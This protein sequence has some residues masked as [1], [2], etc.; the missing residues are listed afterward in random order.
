MNKTILSSYKGVRI[1]MT[2]HRWNA[3]VK[4]LLLVIFVQM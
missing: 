1:V 3:G 4:G 2:I